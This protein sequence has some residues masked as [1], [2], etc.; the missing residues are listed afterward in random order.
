MKRL[1]RLLFAFS[2]VSVHVVDLVSVVVDTY[3]IPLT[4]L[5]YKEHYGVVDYLSMLR[6]ETNVNRYVSVEFIAVARFVGAH[7]A[8]SSDNAPCGT[9]S[10]GARHFLLYPRPVGMVRAV[11]GEWANPERV[12]EYL[13]REIPHRD[14]AEGMLLEALPERVGRV[15]DLGTGDGRLLALVCGRHIGVAGVG[16]DTSRPM[17]ARAHERFGAGTQVKLAVHDLNEPLTASAPFDVVVSGLAIHHLRDERKR[18]LFVEIHELLVP[19]G[20]FANLD[21]VRSAS[22]QLHE[23]FRRDIGRVED[24]PEDRLAGL[25]EQL[26]WLKDVGFDE[27]DCHFKWQELALMVATRAS[28][29]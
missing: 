12:S 17:L 15:L 9:T 27:V 7:H 20:V 23:R 25:C 28:D 5:F 14:V 3:R 4:P 1:S 26:A 24:D 8:Y 6:K 29:R 16:I 11:T 13:S 18:A 19:G 21:L 22:P 2:I 10:C